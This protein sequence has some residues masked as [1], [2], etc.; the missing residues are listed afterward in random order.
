MAVGGRKL[1]I[2]VELM[3]M[4]YCF[5]TMVSVLL[6]A[7]KVVGIAT[8]EVSS[9]IVIFYVML[10]MLPPLLVENVGALSSLSCFS[11][12]CLVYNCLII[13]AYLFVLGAHDSVLSPADGA[14]GWQGEWNAE[15]LL[16]GQARGSAM[17]YIRA[18]LVFI[19]AFANQTVVPCIY[20]ELRD[21]SVRNMTKVGC[22]TM[23]IVTF[24]YATVNLSGFLTWGDD[25]NSNVLFNYRN[26]LG[27]RH[28]ALCM[29]LL[30]SL[31]AAWTC[32][33]LNAFPCKF[34]LVALVNYR[35]PSTFGNAWVGR[36][37]AV[38]LVLL[39]Y[40]SAV[41]LPSLSVVLE[42]VGA[43]AGVAVMFLLPGGFYL[44]LVPRSSGEL[45][46]P[47]HMY[48]CC[49][50]MLICGVAVGSLG[51]YSAIQDAVAVL[52]PS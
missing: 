22:I 35:A 11:Q 30:T 9:A 23:A 12:F 40:V 15:L 42:L 1:G 14:S 43:T 51:T 18:S 24:I 44:A 26:L 47:F 4:V 36:G 7:A 8:P 17:G 49:Y 31:M 45:G 16:L 37:V 39:A 28:A 19:F 32:F 25:C 34:A 46:G 2:C 6:G 52:M 13:T 21:R 33:P 10:S 38:V 50:L 41:A 3:C 29:A 5:G 48:Q 27:F 20:S